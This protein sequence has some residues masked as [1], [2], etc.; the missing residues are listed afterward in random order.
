VVQE[1]FS[2]A[3]RKFACAVSRE[4]ARRYL[5]EVLAPLCEVLYSEDLHDGLK[6]RDLTVVNPF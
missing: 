6:I 3:S 5:R 2:L 4:E 1:F